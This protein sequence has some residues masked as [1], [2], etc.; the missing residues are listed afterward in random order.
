[1]T[2]PDLAQVKERQQQTWAAG[3]FSAV[4]VRLVLTAE[5]LCEAA[6]VRGGERLLDVATGAG[7]VA[8]AAARRFADAVGVDYVP[9]VL[10][11]ARERAAAEHLDVEFRV[12]DA[13]ALPFPDASFDVVTSTFGAMF[14]PNQPRAAAELAR[15]CRPGGRIAMANWT[16]EGF[17]G[18]L[19]PV[20]GRYV[21]PP[22]GLAS[23]SRWGTEAGLRDLLGPHTGSIAVAERAIPMRFRSP[24]HWVAFFRENFGPV[25]QAFAALDPAGQAALE[26]D[27][28]AL[29]GRFNRADD[30]TMLVDG[31]YL[32]V[33]AVRA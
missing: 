12:G 25:R 30:G 29:I 23:P 27:L 21:P 33:V 2:V 17:A 14:A 6:D 1:M 18:E 19:F 32:E 20:V 5:L 22:P 10:E 9:E 28:L 13:E 8:I 26:R 16:P 3:D 7:N 4:G 31:A 11:R 15:V 24:A